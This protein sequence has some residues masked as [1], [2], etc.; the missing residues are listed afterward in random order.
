MG[1]EFSEGVARV[2]TKDGKMICIDKHGAAVFA[3]PPNVIWAEPFSEG[4]ALA[5][6]RGKGPQNRI[7][8]FVDHTGAYV[9]PPQFL[10]AESFVNGLAK[11]LASEE[12]GYIDKSGHFVWKTNIRGVEKALQMPH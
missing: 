8:G 12:S 4:L 7:F 11:V 3:W 2:Q 5:A 10:G 1:W 6:I 9:I